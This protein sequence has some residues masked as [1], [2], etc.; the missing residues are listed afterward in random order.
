MS[1]LN[2]AFKYYLLQ[3]G[4]WKTHTQLYTHT[5]MRWVMETVLLIKNVLKG[6]SFALSLKRSIPLNLITPKYSWN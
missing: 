5:Q 4:K 2:V 1:I 3:F 6:K